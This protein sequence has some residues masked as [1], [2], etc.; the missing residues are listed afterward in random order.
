MLVGSGSLRSTT[1]RLEIS[2]VAGTVFSAGRE[3]F[4]PNRERELLF[5]IARRR[6]SISAEALMDDLWPDRDADAA[7]DLLKSHL[8]YLRRRLADPAA[9]LRNS[10]GLCLR[11]DASVDLW[12]I[13]SALA[14]RRGKTIEDAVQYTTAREIYDRLRSAP[15]AR[16]MSWRWFGPVAARIAGM[17]REVLQALADYEMRRGRRS[18]ALALAHEIIDHDPFDEEAHEIA[19]ALLFAM[20]NWAAALR[21]FRQYRT[22]LR[23]EFAC[24]P[25]PALVSLLK[26]APPNAARSDEL[27]TDIY[28][29]ITASS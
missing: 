3:V 16:V 12:E 25:S 26:S 7:A 4:L 2:I 24:E 14:A 5:A 17:R 18:E 15:P 6:G 11:D 23:E 28:A 22:I 21:E 13:G 8:Y 19:I 9:V 27:Y 29:D 20:G 1:K 10:D